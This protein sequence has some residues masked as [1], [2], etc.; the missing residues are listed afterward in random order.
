MFY[1]NEI[2]LHYPGVYVAIL[3]LL[4]IENVYNTIYCLPFE[5]GSENRLG[6]SPGTQ[7]AAVYTISK[8]AEIL[9]P[10]IVSIV[11]RLV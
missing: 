9:C 8:L 3:A 10:Y 7:D 4:K 1:L 5:R 6:K 2:R 11:N